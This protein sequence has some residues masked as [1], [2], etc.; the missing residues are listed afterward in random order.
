M[1][2]LSAAD[3]ALFAMLDAA[4]IADADLDLTDEEEYALLLQ[5]DAT[6]LAATARGRQNLATVCLLSL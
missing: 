6:N 4:V 3:L 5:Q 2:D 1:S